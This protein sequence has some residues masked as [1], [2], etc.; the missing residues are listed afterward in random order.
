MAK[1]SPL[2]I[3]LKTHCFTIDFNARVMALKLEPSFF[4]YAKNNNCYIDIKKI[5]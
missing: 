5:N 4:T 2:K 3:S 1:V